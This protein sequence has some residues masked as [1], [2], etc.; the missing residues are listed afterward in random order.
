MSHLSP[1]DD[2]QNELKAAAGQFRRGG[3]IGRGGV[4][5]AH[6]GLIEIGGTGAFLDAGGDQRAV[7]FYRQGD[8]GGAET[9]LIARLA[10]LA[11]DI[12]ANPATPDLRQFCFLQS[13]R[14]P[15]FPGLTLCLP[16]HRR[17][18][19]LLVQGLSRHWRFPLLLPLVRVR[20]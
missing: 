20:V 4:Y 14:G 15:Q 10:L 8:H 7:S 3:R 11:L 18:S 16:P 2:G 6:R 17:L 13:Q 5:G 19:L 9:A 1:E 12:T